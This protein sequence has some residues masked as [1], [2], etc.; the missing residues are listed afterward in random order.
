MTPCASCGS[1]VAEGPCPHCGEPRRAV[2]GPTAAV[3]LLGLSLGAFHCVDKPVEPPYGLPTPHTGAE[4]GDTG[5][6]GETTPE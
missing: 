1:H 5:D 4:T 3:L 2:A 6:T